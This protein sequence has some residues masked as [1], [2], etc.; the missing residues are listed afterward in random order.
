M[1]IIIATQSSSSMFSNLKKNPLP[2]LE[3][4]FGDDKYPGGTLPLPLFG[5][6]V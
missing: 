4:S 6:F 1:M 3:A 5:D 2:V